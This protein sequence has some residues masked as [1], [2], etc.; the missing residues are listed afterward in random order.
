VKAVL[1]KSFARIHHANLVNFG[2]LPL[3]LP[4]GARV[5]QGDELAMAGVRGAVEAG[6][7]ITVKDLT[8][9]KSFE[10]SYDLT[11]RQVKVVLAGGLLNHIKEG[12]A[13]A[14]G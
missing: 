14:T 11:P 5:A 8:N 6:K 7:P 9:G 1:V 4:E 2:I 13:A 10:A 3:V 12:G